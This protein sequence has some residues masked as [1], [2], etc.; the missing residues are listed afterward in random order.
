MRNRHQKP[1]EIVTSI[2]IS[3]AAAE[4]MCIARHE[5]KVVF[6]PFAAPGDIVDLQIIKRKRSY[7]EGKILQLHYASD[8]RVQPLCD[9]FGLCGGCKWQHMVYNEQLQLKQQQ[10][11]DNFD[12]IG[13]FEYPGVMPIKGS[14]KQFF[15]RNK[16]EYTFSDRKW[17]THNPKADEE[18]PDMRGLGFHLPGMFDRILDIEKCYLQDEP[19]NAIRLK[20]KEFAIENNLSFYNVKSH[21][22]LLRNLI[23]RNTRN[24]SLMV[25]LVISSYDECII[26]ELLPML[27]ESF[28]TISALLYVVNPKKND[29]I[30]DLEVKSFKGE[31]FI[32]ESMTSPVEGAPALNFRIGPVSFYQTN[33]VQAEVLYKTAYDF[34]GFKG[35]ELVYDLY[36]GTG[37]IAAYIAGSVSKVIGIEY[38]EEAIKD[39][40]VNTNLNGI[41]NA[42]FIAG[43]MA[44]VLTDELVQEYGKPDVVITDPPRAGMHPKV[45]EQLNAIAASKIVYV[46]CNPATQARDIA[47]LSEKYAVK[48][49]QP[50]DMFPQTHH[51][52]NVVLLE[53]KA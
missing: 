22:G 28:P 41:N 6:V 29:Q 15:Y 30:H 25:I 10:V 34:A 42:V 47:L 14:E 32:T 36:T 20:V 1:P 2:E 35:D 33:P 4:G 8:F 26:K 27:A 13:K 39:A 18:K 52:E 45:I 19:S 3:H 37:T 24:G 46:S 9:H 5:Q 49:V 17:L 51:V 50:I 11:T 44:K 7:F 40:R 12:R 43:D 38:V 21:E 16:L 53:L 23:I 31:P 48:A